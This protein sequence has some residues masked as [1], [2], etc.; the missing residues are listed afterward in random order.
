MNTAVGIRA[1]LLLATVDEEAAQRE[2]RSTRFG[3]DHL[4]PCG[5][6]VQARLEFDLE[7]SDRARPD[8][9]RCRFCS[10]GRV[11]AGDVQGRDAH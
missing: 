11:T 5:A 2:L 10:L 7:C 8:P 1:R 3:Y 9:V 6:T 4:P